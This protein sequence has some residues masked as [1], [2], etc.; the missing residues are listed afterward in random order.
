M[1][2]ATI[3]FDRQIR[4]PVHGREKQKAI[5]SASQVSGTASNV[6]GLGFDFQRSMAESKGKI[7]TGEQMISWYEKVLES[8]KARYR[9]LQR[10][11]R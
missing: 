2:R 4:V 3:N 1:T 9:K 10:F 5:P 8:V 6:N 11:S 7:M